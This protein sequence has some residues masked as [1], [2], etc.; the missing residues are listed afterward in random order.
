MARETKRKSLPK[1]VRM[2][3][4][5]EYDGHCAY[6]GC[7]LDYK[8]MQVDHINSVYRSIAIK[9][10]V[11]ECMGNYMP[12][13]RQCN[14]YKSTFTLEAFRKNLTDVLM[15][16]LQKNF[17]YRLAL[18]YGLIRENIKPITF[19]FEKKGENND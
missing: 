18:K 11:D 10:C 15:K 13:C 8:D 7:K 19:Y 4:Y 1:E 16:N 2:R 5:R 9:G 3:I 14:F 12:S 6:C 17:N